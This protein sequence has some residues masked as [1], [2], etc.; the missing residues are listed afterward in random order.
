MIWHVSYIKILCI[1]NPAQFWGYYFEVGL[2][3]I[4][5]DIEISLEHG[6]ICQMDYIFFSGNNFAVINIFFYTYNF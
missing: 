2:D 3:K 6:Q 5:M 4:L 1:V